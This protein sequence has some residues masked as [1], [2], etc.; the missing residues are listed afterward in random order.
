MPKKVKCTRNVYFYYNN[1]SLNVKFHL[2]YGPAFLWACILVH[3]T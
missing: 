1:F 2:I 3:V